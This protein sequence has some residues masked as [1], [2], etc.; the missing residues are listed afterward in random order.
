MTWKDNTWDHGGL[1]AELADTKASLWRFGWLVALTLI[2]C[3]APL[4]FLNFYFGSL[5]VHSLHVVKV[6][7]DDLVTHFIVL[8]LLLEV[9]VVD[10]VADFV[11]F[12]DVGN[13]TIHVLM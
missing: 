1:L 5:A 4:C 2:H 7:G 3:F 9:V 8:S 12:K 10:G 6:S 11:V 13:A